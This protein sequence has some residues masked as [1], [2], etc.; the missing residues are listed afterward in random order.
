MPVNSR[1][2]RQHGYGYMTNTLSSFEQSPVFVIASVAEKLI[3]AGREVALP[4][5]YTVEVLD[6]VKWLTG[7][8]DR[9]IAV[10]GRQAEEMAEIG[11]QLLD[12]FPDELTHSQA[13]GIRW[14]LKVIGN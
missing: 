14:M 10:S 12:N 4:G 1:I 7:Y 2:F 11:R 3:K 9:D 8:Y 13:E 6:N 5:E